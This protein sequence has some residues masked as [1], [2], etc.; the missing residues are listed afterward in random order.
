MAGHNELGKL[1]EELAAGF[2]KKAGYQILA[3]NWV[4]MK[5]EIDIIATKDD[6]LAV[7]EV[8]TR[9]TL[10]FGLPQEFVKP[11]KIRLLVRAIDAY[12]ELNAIDAEVRFDIISIHKNNNAFEI[13]HIEDA[14][15]YF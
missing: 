6:V 10:E 3:T 14:F 1:G 9:S 11:A 13:E 4:Y 15:F 5:A 8:K 12:I 2:L 7:I